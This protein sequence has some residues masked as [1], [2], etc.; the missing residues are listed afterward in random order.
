MTKKKKVIILVCILLS[1][2]V[3]AWSLCNMR[4]SRNTERIVTSTYETAYAL[5]GYSYFRLNMG[6]G[7]ILS[8][9]DYQTIAAGSSGIWDEEHFSADSQFDWDWD[10]HSKTI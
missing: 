2:L 5:G 10:I 6:F 3:I 9:K 4:I 7:S 8:G 1:I